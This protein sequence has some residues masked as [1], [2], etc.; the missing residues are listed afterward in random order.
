M[1]SLPDVA[2]RMWGQT[3]TIGQ[4]VLPYVW[5]TV[6]IALCFGLLIVLFFLIRAMLRISRPMA[7]YCVLR[8]VQMFSKSASGVRKAISRKRD[9]SSGVPPISR[10]KWFQGWI[11]GNG[12]RL[13]RVTPLR[14]IVLGEEGVRQYL[15]N[16][17]RSKRRTSWAIE[18]SDG[19]TVSID[20]WLLDRDLGISRDILSL[21]LDGT[22]AD[23]QNAL[24]PICSEWIKA[25]GD[26]SVDRL[27]ICVT[28]GAIR[29]FS[30]SGDGP[31]RNC[32]E[33]VEKIGGL[34][35][36]QIPVSIVVADARSISGYVEFREFAQESNIDC[37]E[38]LHYAAGEDVDVASIGSD[39]G[40][41]IGV[42]LW[43]ELC[44]SSF[45]RISK[46]DDDVLR[47]ANHF[48]ELKKSL[49]LWIDSLVVNTRG[50]ST[51][52]FLREIYIGELAGGSNASGGAHQSEVVEGE[53]GRELSLLDYLSNSREHEYEVAGARPTREYLRLLHR[54]VLVAAMVSTLTV[55]ILFAWL[56]YRFSVVAKYQD[57]LNQ[58]RVRDLA[59]KA[60]EGS[61][62]LGTT[63][64]GGNRSPGT[65]IGDIAAISR[66]STS[67]F[68]VPASWANSDAN[69]VLEHLGD[70][71]QTRAVAPR[72]RDILS[73]GREAI[74]VKPIV[75]PGVSADA[76]IELPAGIY[77]KNLLDQIEPAQSLLLLEKSARG[78]ITY[79]EISRFLGVNF[80]YFTD[81]GEEPEN[82][83]PKGV[84]ERLTFKVPKYDL[85]PQPAFNKII[86]GAW[87]CVL[88]EG[89]D[90]NPINADRKIV[91][92]L[93]RHWTEGNQPTN[94][95]LLE[96]SSALKRIRSSFDS[97]NAQYLLGGDA[98]FEQYFQSLIWRMKK[99]SLIQQSSINEYISKSF[100][101]RDSFRLQLVK[102][103][104]PGVGTMFVRDTDS[105][106]I[107]LSPDFISFSKK[108]QDFVSK[109][110]FKKPVEIGL[111]RLPPWDARRLNSVKTILTAKDEVAKSGL[112]QFDATWRQGLFYLIQEN[113]NNFVQE[114]F[115]AA[116]G[117]KGELPAA[118]GDLRS[119]IN[120]QSN[121][122]DFLAA[123]K[124]YRM[125]VPLGEEINSGQSP[126]RMK[127]EDAITG[128]LLELDENFRR[129]N[130]F[131][132]FSQKLVNRLEQQG[133]FNFREL[134]NEVRDRSIL[135]REEV[136]KIYVANAL[137]LIDAMRLLVGS[138]FREDVWAFWVSLTESYRDYDAGNGPNGIREFEKIADR[139]VKIN[140][141]FDCERD[142]LL[143]SNVLFKTDF[144]SKTA[145]KF[146]SDAQVLCRKLIYGNTIRKY[147]EFANWFNK[148]VSGR[149]PFF[150][151]DVAASAVGPLSQREFEGVVARF[152][153]SSLSS[154]I[155]RAK[156]V[157]ASVR[158][159][160]RA[161]AAVQ[162]WFDS[163][164]STAKE[165]IFGK[166][167]LRLRVKLRTRTPMAVSSNQIIDASIAVGMQ[168]VGLTGSDALEWRPGETIE[169]KVRWA[170]QAAERPVVSAD[171]SSY[172]VDGRSV[173]FKFSGEWS[174]MDLIRQY[175]IKEVEN[176]R[177]IVKLPINVVRNGQTDLAAFVFV[178]E[179]PTQGAPIALRAPGKAP[180]WSTDTLERDASN[181][182]DRQ[183]VDMILGH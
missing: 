171:A 112:E 162:M 123:A 125:A 62:G 43:N 31:M 12:L 4:T 145:R 98:E 174:L 46:R 40:K 107:S 27:V 54:Q 173:L 19:E 41:G 167:P 106:L 60:P 36:L 121:I 18:R 142:L 56:P 114:I 122:K 9:S 144:I 2:Q 175:S 80:K 49:C 89:I 101:M 157:P 65:L 47:F 148:R 124:L 170:D 7:R 132:E 33:I 113:I 183:L 10:R 155:E 172:R 61:E 133:G 161:F 90:G 50:S 91:V 48:A 52:P 129:S 104:I 109:P 117:V 11:S 55:L 120:H 39:W 147:N 180:M 70:V 67:V 164:T 22:S 8:L 88:M 3:L 168:E 38:I 115:V 84:A 97:G 24:L 182:S 102:T 87:R 76:A 74:N 143:D 75:T 116:G 58:V 23:F 53:A 134:T 79:A 64:S 141:N 146:A 108:F 137:E 100:Q 130:P 63:L 20:R 32:V 73:E 149:A 139:L 136:R 82:V 138:N 128:C 96:M 110:F 26:Y 28:V 72:I 154:A 34:S 179:S 156:V 57:Y 111:D 16:T 158:S 177:V 181:G 140:E 86:D 93:A 118:S 25:D 21:P 169:V 45:T 127:L 51:A 37:N 178:L 66:G 15:V 1:S 151:N 17:S 94:D 92:E 165:G 152:E 119:C 14:W 71:L 83:L 78:S 135:V 103:K 44:V 85:I 5:L 150:A 99:S 163:G 160:A 176:E 69:D 6:L 59:V 30:Q 35:C 29:R 126:G 81:Y 13:R 166:Q 68:L 105:G 42:R 95:E 77:L 159:F 131:N 153:E